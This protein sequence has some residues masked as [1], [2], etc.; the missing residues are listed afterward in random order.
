ME[1]REERHLFHKS[2]GKW[3]PCDQSLKGKYVS[4]WLE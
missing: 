4:L 1:H 3:E 2:D